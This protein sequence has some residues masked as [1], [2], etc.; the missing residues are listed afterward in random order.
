MAEWAGTKLNMPVLALGGESSLGEITMTLYGAVANN[1]RGGV[2]PECGHWVAEERPDYLV[3]QL[4][5]FFS[6]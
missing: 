3:D 4:L 2:I 1:I 5:A 6:A